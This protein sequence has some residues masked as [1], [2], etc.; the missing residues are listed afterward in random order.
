MVGLAEPEPRT[1]Q[2]HLL[3]DLGSDTP[4][5]SRHR[6][7]AANVGGCASTNTRAD[8]RSNNIGDNNAD[9]RPRNTRDKGRNK[10]APQIH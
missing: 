3:L 2:A 4:Q 5:A 1:A 10:R 9:N 7:S 6:A 8:Y